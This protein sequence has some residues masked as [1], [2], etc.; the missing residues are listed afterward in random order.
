M[1]YRNI[2]NVKSTKKGFWNNAYQLWLIASNGAQTRGT[3]PQL[4]EESKLVNILVK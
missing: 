3:R 2:S 4:P 1:L